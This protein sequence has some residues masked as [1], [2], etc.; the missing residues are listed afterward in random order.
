MRSL[1]QSQISWWRSKQFDEV[2]VLQRLHTSP[3][4]NGWCH[5]PHS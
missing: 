3:S 5:L 4:C 1:T 2:Y